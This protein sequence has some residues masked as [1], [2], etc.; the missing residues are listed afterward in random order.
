LGP[1]APETKPTIE[2]RLLPIPS[3][4]TRLNS[5]PPPKLIDPENRTTLRPVGQASLFHLISSPSQPAAPQE[6]VP[7]DGGWRASPE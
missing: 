7:S 3:T 2:S 4:D 5:T 1:T 6:A